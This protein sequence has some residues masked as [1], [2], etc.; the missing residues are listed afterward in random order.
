MSDSINID[1]I[2]YKYMKRRAESAEAKLDEI[3]DIT[4]FVFCKDDLIKKINDIAGD[5][6]EKNRIKKKNTTKK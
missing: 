1:L 4:S 3:L 5:K 6:N 2:D